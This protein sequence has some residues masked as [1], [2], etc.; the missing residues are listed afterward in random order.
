MTDREFFLSNLGKMDFRSG[1]SLVKSNVDIARFDCNKCFR[2]CTRRIRYP[3]C[4]HA[5]CADCLADL[6]WDDNIH[7]MCC[8]DPYCKLCYASSD[9]VAEKNDSKS[10]MLFEK[11]LYDDIPTPFCTFRDHV[12]SAPNSVPF[13]CDKCSVASTRRIRFV[14]CNHAI[15]APCLALLIWDAADPDHFLCCEDAS[16]QICETPSSVVAESA[17]STRKLYKVRTE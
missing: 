9:V 17:N 3:T 14:A 11:R 8:R 16:C 2:Q 1:R 4:N 6:I 7:F 12:T 10:T 13:R 15:C 5:I